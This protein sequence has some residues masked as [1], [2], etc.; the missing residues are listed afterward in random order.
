MRFGLLILTLM[1]SSCSTTKVARSTLDLEL[2]EAAQYVQDGYYKDAARIYR[3]ILKED[4]NH[5]QARKNL[6]H[7][8]IKM[9]FTHGGEVHL[10]LAEKSAVETQTKRISAF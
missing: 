7:C 2:R 5:S 8:L 10:K 1:V 4:P 3:R 9:G 6:G